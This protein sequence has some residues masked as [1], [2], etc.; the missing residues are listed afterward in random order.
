MTLPILI[1]IYLLILLATVYVAK[2]FLIDIDEEGGLFSWYYDKILFP[3]KEKNSKWAKPLGACELCFTTWLGSILGTAYVLTLLIHF[4]L[5]W[6]LLI[7]PSYVFLSMG[8]TAFF[9]M[10]TTKEK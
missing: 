10:I 1:F 3:L 5:Y 8:L 7:T 4:R 2:L 6:W 9:M